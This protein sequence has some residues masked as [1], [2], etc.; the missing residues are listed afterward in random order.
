MSAKVEIPIEVDDA[1]VDLDDRLRTALE[2]LFD[3]EFDKFDKKRSPMFADM[4][5]QQMADLNKFCALYMSRKYKQAKKIIDD[6]C[7][8]IFFDDTINNWLE[9]I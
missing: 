9:T 2:C 4:S 3:N 6:N 5:L 8:D 1:I 7:L